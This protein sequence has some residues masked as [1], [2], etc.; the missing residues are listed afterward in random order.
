MSE[1]PRRSETAA[2]AGPAELLARLPPRAFEEESQRA[3]EM[4]ELCRHAMEQQLVCCTDPSLQQL[5]LP[6]EDLSVYVGRLERATRSLTALLHCVQQDEQPRQEVVELCA[7]A[8]TLC[9]GQDVI[10]EQLGI[11]LQLDCAGLDEL[12]IHAD[13]RY[14]SRI[15]LHLLSNA[16][17]ACTPEGGTVTLALRP[18]GKNGA[19]LTLTDT[20][21]GLPDG[22]LDAARENRRHFLGGLGAGLLLC[23]EYCRLAGWTLELRPRTHGRGAE[24]LLTIPAR[25]AANPYPIL[26]APDASDLR[27]A[28]RRL[29]YAM[30][31]ELS[32][33]PGLETANFKSPAELS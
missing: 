21:C 26:R 30:A 5:R 28:G 16:L 2:P 10:R 33:V 13:R 31:F 4:I 9:S 20:G 14:L 29:W 23:G 15:C 24:A 32:S 12:Y 7:F 8:R 22:T 18:L 19:T 25:T 1:N 17:R 27:R 11:R 3:L 6:L